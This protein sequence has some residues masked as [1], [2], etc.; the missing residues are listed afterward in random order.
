MHEMLFSLQFSQ[1]QADKKNCSFTEESS[2]G[3]FVGM[4]GLTLTIYRLPQGRRA[5]YTPE[6]Q[7]NTLNNIKCF[8]NNQQI[9]PLGALLNYIQ[10]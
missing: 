7:E 10:S 9:L 8:I 4:D 1:N 6:K 3:I 2:S 5:Y